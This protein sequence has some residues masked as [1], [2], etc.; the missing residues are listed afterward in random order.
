MVYCGNYIA[1][2]IM[3]YCGNYIARGIIFAIDM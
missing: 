2:D 3:V 1:R